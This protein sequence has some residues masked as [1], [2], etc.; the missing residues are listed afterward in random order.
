MKEKHMEVHV[1]TDKEELMEAIQAAGT[2][3]MPVVAFIVPNTREVFIV[4][5]RTMIPEIVGMII[6][7][8]VQGKEAEVKWMES[9]VKKIMKFE[10]C[11]VCGQLKRVPVGGKVITEEDADVVPLEA[12]GKWVCSLR[13]FKELVHLH[14]LIDHGKRLKRMEQAASG[15]VIMPNPNKKP[16]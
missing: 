5:R 7:N 13:C 3:E 11:F 16:N 6:P 1:V 12:I 4:D 8:H 10:P 2:D 14:F 15:M 9:F